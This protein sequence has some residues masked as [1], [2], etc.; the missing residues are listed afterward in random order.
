MLTAAYNQLK[1]RRGVQDGMDIRLTFD[2][3]CLLITDRC[4]YCGCYPK[5]TKFCQGYKLRVPISGIDRI[6]NENWYGVD[7]CVSCCW[8]CNKMKNTLTQRKFLLKIRQ[9]AKKHKRTVTW[10]VT[11]KWWQFV[12]RTD[13]HNE[14]WQFNSGSPFK[15]TS[16]NRWTV[17]N[18][19][20]VAQSFKSTMYM[21]RQFV[22]TVQ[23]WNILTLV[24]VHFTVATVGA[25]KRWQFTGAL[26]DSSFKSEGWHQSENFNPVFNSRFLPES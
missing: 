8:T 11:K 9:I 24:T 1:K 4:F 12:H 16:K 2:E 23:F 19:Y 10:T 6:N 20:I 25:R 13:L 26:G 3:F 21:W 5:M 14:W 17:T 22:V 7:N 15:S 18:P